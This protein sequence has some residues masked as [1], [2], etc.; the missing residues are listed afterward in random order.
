MEAVH[1][2]MAPCRARLGGYPCFM[3]SGLLNMGRRWSINGPIRLLNIFSRQVQQADQEEG[4]EIFR[5]P[6]ESQ[7]SERK[8]YRCSF[9]SLNGFK[10]S[11]YGRKKPIKSMER[12]EKAVKKAII[13]STDGRSDGSS[14]IVL[15][16]DLSFKLRVK[17]YK[18][19]HFYN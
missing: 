14:P 4:K 3:G 7:F 15:T 17:I 19:V 16:E 5:V 10:I 9:E 1:T 6:K 8:R 2:E 18:Q 11:P 13:R 12:L